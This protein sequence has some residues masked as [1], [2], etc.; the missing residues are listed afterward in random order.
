V[1]DYFAVL[2]TL[3]PSIH[4]SMG[5][6]PVGVQCP[7][8]SSLGEFLGYWDGSGILGF[9][10]CWCP[11]A[12]PSPSISW[13]FSITLLRLPLDFIRVSSYDRRICTHSVDPSLTHPLGEF[14]GLGLALVLD[15]VVPKAE[16]SCT[17]S[18]NLNP[19]FCPGR[20]T[21][22]LGI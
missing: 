3:T 11:S 4:C 8:T 18:R 14:P 9:R 19:N 13:C 20:R 12:F 5:S 6:T 17:W 10:P 2:Y 15:V 16:Q 22:D 21:S 7:L 1:P